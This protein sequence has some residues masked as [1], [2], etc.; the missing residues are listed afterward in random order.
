MYSKNKKLMCGRYYWFK[1]Q[2]FQYDRTSNRWYKKA[3]NNFSEQLKVVNPRISNKE[4]LKQELSDY[5]KTRNLTTR[6]ENN[7]GK[8]S[9]ES[10]SAA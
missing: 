6:L 7:E 3:L 1:S 8:T 5:I 2:L 10:D 4:L 9:K